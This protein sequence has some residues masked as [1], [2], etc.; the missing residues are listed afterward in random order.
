LS[1]RKADYKLEITGTWR[2]VHVRAC[3]SVGWETPHVTTV[4]Q[5]KPRNGMAI[6]GRI[7]H[8][9]MANMEKILQ[10]LLKALSELDLIGL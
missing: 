2:S 3:V 9:T 10:T 7:S 8:G 6:N 4:S 1:I 5:S